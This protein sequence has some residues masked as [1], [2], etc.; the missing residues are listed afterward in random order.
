MKYWLILF[1]I[2]L[3]A[4]QACKTEQQATACTNYSSIEFNGTLYIQPKDSPGF[5]N[6]YTWQQAV[7]YCNNLDFDGCDDWYLPTVN[8]LVEITNHK[9]SIGDFP[10][11]DPYAYWSSTID[12]NH[13]DESYSVSNYSSTVGKGSTPQYEVY[14][15]R[16]VRN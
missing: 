13:S 10:A 6:T 4:F 9:A 2:A 3:F 7:D 14:R 5:T 15:C 1:S 16:C 8:E 11:S 12:P